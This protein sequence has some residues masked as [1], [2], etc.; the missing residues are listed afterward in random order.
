[1]KKFLPIL[2]LTLAAIISLPIVGSAQQTGFAR[3]HDVNDSDIRAALTFSDN[4][5]ELRV[6]GIAT[7]LDPT[8]QY[9]TLLYDAGSVARGPSACLPTDNSLTFTQMVV[10]FWKVDDDGNGRFSVRKKGSSYIPLSAVGTSSVRLDTQPGQPL[11][12]APDPNRFVLQACGK[13]RQ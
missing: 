8:R 3:L 13:V 12:T 7:G 5:A 4:G 2:P 9:V 1:M 6:I 10:K 11:P